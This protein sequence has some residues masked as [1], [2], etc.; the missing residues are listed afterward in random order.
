LLLLFG[1]IDF[2]V[3]I[4][5]Q[6]SVTHAA[7]EGARDA[8]TAQITA[9]DSGSNCAAWVRVAQQVATTSV[10]WMSSNTPTFTPSFTPN[11]SGCSVSYNSGTKTWTGSG[12]GSGT[13]YLTITVGANS[14]L[15]NLPGIGVVAPSSVSSSATVQLQ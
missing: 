15:P 13:V 9:P 4:G 5:L 14:I 1:I 12:T 8:Q 2:G 6:Q 10:G 11:T 3:D 7:A